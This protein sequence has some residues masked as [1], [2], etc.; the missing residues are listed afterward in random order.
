M[1]CVC[2]TQ[3]HEGHEA[4]ILQGLNNIHFLMSHWALFLALGECCT[5]VDKIFRYCCRYPTLVCKKH[6]CA[7]LCPPL[8]GKNISMCCAKL[9]WFFSRHVFPDEISIVESHVFCHPS[10]KQLNNHCPPDISQQLHRCDVD[11]K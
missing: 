7:F 3:C 1:V 11:L 2:F 9:L 10:A 6:C 4:S 5:S 8:P